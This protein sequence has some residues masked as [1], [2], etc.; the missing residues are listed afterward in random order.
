MYY[1]YQVVKYGEDIDDT[2]IH[3][4]FW[5]TNAS[6][7]FGDWSNNGCHYNATVQDGRVV[8]HCYHLTSFAVLVVR[9][10]ETF[11]Q[12]LLTVDNCMDIN[13]HL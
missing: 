6:N 10:K 3:C 11:F 1:T 9:I 13:F 5:D 12:F 2:S 4:V 8:C 7:G